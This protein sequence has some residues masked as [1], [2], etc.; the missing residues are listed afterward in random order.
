VL[1]QQSTVPV[2]GPRRHP[3]SR[4]QRHH[5]Q[6]GVPDDRTPIFPPP[7]RP[8]E[9]ARNPAS[10][11]TILRLRGADWAV[12]AQQD[13]TAGQRCLARY[14]PMSRRWP[15][16][17]PALTSCSHRG[18]TRQKATS[19]TCPKFLHQEP[20]HVG[21]VVHAQELRRQHE[22]E[23]RINAL[24]SPVHH[25]VAQECGCKESAP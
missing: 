7:R 5:S 18:R 4:A 25:E 19:R 6:I 8:S 12:S 1:K 23:Q 3:A 13:R 11:T 20:S 22:P 9:A 2:G 17:S 15:H 16:E 10:K 24:N 21:C 14:Q